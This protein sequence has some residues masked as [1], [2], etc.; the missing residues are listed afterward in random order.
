[1]ND[2]FQISFR[3]CMDPGFREEEDLKLLLRFVREARVDDVMVF[4]NVEELNTGHTTPEEQE[5]YKELIARIKGLLTPENATVS[6]NPWH[7]VMHAD[8]GKFLRPGQDFRLMTDPDGR[9]AT[10]CVCPMDEKWQAYIEALYRNFAGLHPNLLWVE[11][12]FRFHNHEPLRWGGCFCKEHMA[13]YSQMAGRPLTR[14]EFLEGVLAPGPVHPYR[15]IWLDACRKTLV[16]LAVRI[17]KGA[18]EASE[19]ARMGLMSS[20]PH[21]HAAEGRDWRGLL[22]GLSA[23]KIPVNRIHLPGY[24]EPTPSTYMMHF[25][26]VSMMNRAFVPKETEI[27]PELENF[28]YSRF[29]KSLRFTRF[30][31]LSAMPLNMT[32]ITADLFDLNGN[33]IVWEEGYQTVLKET[34]TYLDR[35]TRL[36]VFKGRAGGVRVLVSPDSSYTLY[37]REGKAMEELY[38]H[39]AFFGSWLPALGIPF[40]Y[41]T[42]P[43]LE[44]VTAAVSGQYLRNLT[45]SQIEKL[46]SN[47]FIL[48]NGDAAFTLYEMGLGGLAHIRD[49]R[50]MPQNTGLYAYEQATGEGTC[51]GVTKARASALISLS[52]ALHIDYGE[53]ARCLSVLYDSF[54]RPAA[55]GLTLASGQALILPFGRFV[56]PLDIPRMLLTSVRQALMQNA[57]TTFAR[58]FECPP[59]LLGHP[60]VNPYYYPGEDGFYLYLV[61]ASTDDCSR[62]VLDAGM[63]NTRRIEAMLPDRVDTVSL[64]FESKGSELAFELNL[65]GMDAALLHFIK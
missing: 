3:F 6:V 59:V 49:A 44:G 60:Y 41:T 25:N 27:Y 42:D 1:M 14:E 21:V 63:A 31:L 61:N 50:W 20:A 32:G 40:A 10:L 30:Q 56:H 47:N 22:T 35:L 17:G 15:K 18:R 53:D 54:R 39:E 34:R 19:A 43:D 16:D 62:F 37:T 7:T 13:L 33:G 55:P 12:D 52:D 29:N 5:R 51:C 58:N 2:R 64:P 48:L 24:T 65:K 4:V 57:L 23:G 36:G 9:E 8:L 46:F 11:D 28:P 45:K 26:S 38:P